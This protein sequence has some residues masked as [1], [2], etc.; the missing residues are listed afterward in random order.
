MSLFSRN[1]GSGSI[2]TYSPAH[3]ETRTTRSIGKQRCD[4]CG[5]PDPSEDHL[6]ECAEARERMALV[7]HKTGQKFRA[8]AR[9]RGE[10][11]KNHGKRRAKT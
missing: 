4:L 2:L 5:H 1:N 7:S 9:L 10:M 6:R 11:H 8:Q 3:T